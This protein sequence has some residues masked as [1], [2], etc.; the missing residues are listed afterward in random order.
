M[1]SFERLQLTRRGWLAT[2]AAVSLSS[3]AHAVEKALPTAA[4][5]ARELTSALKGNSPLLV[6]VSLERCPFCNTARENYLAPLLHQAGLVIVQLD[7][8][9]QQMVQDF[10]GASLTHEQLIR[11]WGIKIAPTVLFFG[12]GGVEVAERLVG[13]YIPDFYGAY[14][15]GRLQTARAAVLL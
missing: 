8:R 11:R 9:S 12:P 6:M 2:V 5:L 7:M 10:A 15:D 1:V 4:S 14:L 3:T 13:G